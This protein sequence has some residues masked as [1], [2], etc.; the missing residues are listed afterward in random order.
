M[1]LEL[2]RPGE[3]LSRE[4]KEFR[5]E[6]E[7]AGGIYGVAWSVEEGKALLKEWGVVTCA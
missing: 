2:K 7:R 4:Q 6:W 3:T 5:V 1:G